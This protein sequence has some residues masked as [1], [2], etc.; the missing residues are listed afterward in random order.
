[1]RGPRASLERDCKIHRLAIPVLKST[2]NMV[3]SPRSCVGASKKCRNSVMHVRSCCFAHKSFC[4]LDVI[5]AV[6][7]V[8]S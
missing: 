4:V 1:M 2:Q 5:V 7:V 8:V 3:I 6:D